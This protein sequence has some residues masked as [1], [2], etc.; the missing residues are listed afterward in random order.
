MN[1]CATLSTGMVPFKKTHKPRESLS[2]KPTYS[3][4]LVPEPLGQHRE[5]LFWKTITTTTTTTKD[6]ITSVGEDM[7][8]CEHAYSIGGNVKWYSCFGKQSGSSSR[9]I[10][11]YHIKQ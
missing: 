4:E 11:S 7:G 6:T 3:T 2:S 10:Q 9:V 8:K 5:T 1:K